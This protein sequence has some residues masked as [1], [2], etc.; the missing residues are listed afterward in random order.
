MSGHTFSGRVAIAGIGATEFSK[1]SGRSELR[2]ATE[3]VD[4]AL[5]DAGIEPAEV[6]GMV[7]FSS[8]TNPDIDIARGLGMGDL[9]FFSRIHYGGGAAAGTVQQA[10]LAVEAGVADVVVCL[11]RLQRA[12]RLALWCGG[13]GPPPDPPTGER[14]P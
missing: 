13:P 12:L 14:A 5:K 4:L 2:L 3:A 10:A 8:D 1:E 11:P 9:T 7:S 6:E